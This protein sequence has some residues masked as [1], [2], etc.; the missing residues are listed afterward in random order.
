MVN[1]KR[2]APFFGFVKIK[3]IARFLGPSIAT[4][5]AMCYTDCDEIPSMKE[6]K[7]QWFRLTALSFTV[8][9]DSNG[10]GLVNEELEMA[11]RGTSS[12]TTSK[13]DSTK[14]MSD[15]SSVGVESTSATPSP[16]TFVARS[17]SPSF[18]NVES[19]RR[20]STSF[21]STDRADSVVSLSSLQ[22]AKSHE[23]SD[24]DVA[25]LSSLWLRNRSRTMSSP[26]D[27]DESRSSSPAA[28]RTSF[29][30][31]VDLYPMRTVL[32]P[33]SKSENDDAAQKFSEPFDFR[34]RGSNYLIDRKKIPCGEP[35]LHLLG[36]DLHDA[37]PSQR[38]HILAQ[39]N[40]HA[41]KFIARLGTRA[42]WMFVI[43]FMVPSGNISIYFASPLPA[44]KWKKQLPSDDLLARFIDGSDN[45]R[46]S[47]LKL[48]PRIVKGNWFV[49]KVVGTKPAIL[50]TK[51]LGIEYIRAPGYLEMDI[52]LTQSRVA[53]G[54][55]S[56]V[57]QYAESLVIDLAFVIESQHASEMPE[58]LLSSVRFH[59]GRFE[60][61][62]DTTEK[63]ETSATKDADVGVPFID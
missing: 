58:R 34:V 11:E 26:H 1:E 24:D 57:Q 54:I 41:S 13:Y 3:R 63:K 52:D 8:D 18:G 37:A 50:G 49:R 27:V 43:N 12:F 46:N 15:G 32:R 17:A 48:I 4:L 21:R 47:R 2:R 36:S 6:A 60:A 33:L 22:T 10:G 14:L 62:V 23:S 38:R 16:I 20:L 44:A 55:W 9:A 40:H 30:D 5:D 45:F 7:L 35:R 31:F 29:F 42:P 59:H 56:V 39:P 53:N 61:R 51:G 28:S 19:K 25:P